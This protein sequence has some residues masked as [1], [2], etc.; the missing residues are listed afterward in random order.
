MEC[1]QDI[2]MEWLESYFNMIYKIIWKQNKI[3]LNEISQREN[4]PLRDIESQFLPS[5]A[6]LR[7]FTAR[8][9]DD[10]RV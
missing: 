7:K 9:H 1:S 3:L 5:R 8:T 10:S 2:K 6:A 4:I